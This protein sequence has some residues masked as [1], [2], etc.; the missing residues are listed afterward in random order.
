MIFIIS[1]ADR[2]GKKLDEYLQ[3]IRE[4][5]LEDHVLLTC[6][7][8]SFVKLINDAD[9][10]LRP[11]CTDGDALT[12]REAL[13]LNKPVVASDVVTRPEGAITFK[14]RDMFDLCAKVTNLL[15][16]GMLP[17]NMIESTYSYRDFYKKLYCLSY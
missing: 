17:Y 5:R 10:V 9:I 4:L 8:L 6:A 11:T 3:L 16:N 13:Y 1:S 15:N 2:A 12:I 7:S 14:N